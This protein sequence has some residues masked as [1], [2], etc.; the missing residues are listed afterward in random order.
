[1]AILDTIRVILGILF[2]IFGLA[3]GAGAGAGGAAVGLIYLFLAFVFLILLA[4]K[5]K[6][7]PADDP[8]ENGYECP[9][10]HSSNAIKLSRQVTKISTI[11]FL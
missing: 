2:V 4:P 8:M 7:A 1:M 6:S 10:C 5:K 3:M 11:Q 9:Q